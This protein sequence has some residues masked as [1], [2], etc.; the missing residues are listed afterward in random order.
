MLADWAREL[1]VKK[2]KALTYG[3]SNGGVSRD[4]CLVL[5]KMSQAS[6]QPLPGA[7]A[8]HDAGQQGW[9]AIWH[10]SGAYQVGCIPE[11]HS[12]HLCSSNARET[13]KLCFWAMPLELK[14]VAVCIGMMSNT[15]LSSVVQPVCWRGIG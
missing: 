13:Q 1:S 9:A 11:S 15:L 5:G 4:E 7:A 12:C 8:V 14:L 3:G 2:E 6:E 10:F